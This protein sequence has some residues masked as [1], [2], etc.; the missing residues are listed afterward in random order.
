[1]ILCQL[2]PHGMSGVYRWKQQPAVRVFTPSLDG[3]ERFMYEM[4]GL[5]PDVPERSR[6]EAGDDQQGG[7][8]R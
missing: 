6:H 8:S 5:L 3:F 1:M 7:Q 4:V 2:N